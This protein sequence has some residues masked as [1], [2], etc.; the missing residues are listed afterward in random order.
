MKTII[1]ASASSLILVLLAASFA[2]PHP[3]FALKNFF[4]CITDISAKDGGDHNLTLQQ[5]IDCFKKEFP[6]NNDNINSFSSSHSFSTHSN[7]HSSIIIDHGHIKS[8][9]INGFN[10]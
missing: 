10:H 8:E 9:I 6:S 4:G 5:V 1:T 3:A 7:T 2:A